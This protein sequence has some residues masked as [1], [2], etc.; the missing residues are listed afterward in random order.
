MLPDVRGGSEV[1]ES[2]HRF[3]RADGSTVWLE[4]SCRAVPAESIVYGSARDITDRKR[5]EEDL[6]RAHEMVENSRDELA[7]SRAR[8]VAAAAEERQRVVR[9]IHDGAQQSLVHTIITLKMALGDAQDRG[10]AT[11]A[12]VGEA[13]GHAEAA[14]AKLRA[15]A[16][17]ILPPV[18]ATG[19]LRAGI[20]ELASRSS[21]P[22]T[23][24]VSTDRLASAIEATAYFVV[25]ESLTN[26]MKHSGAQ[27][28]EVA[29]EITA[30]ALRV[31]IRDD[32]VG[33]AEPSAS[34]GL[35]GLRDRV[36]AFGGTIEIISPA[37]LGTS[38]IVVIPLEEAA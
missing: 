18:L 30:G 10:G 16:H 23:T 13:L 22:V 17:G 5:S 25:S 3:V 24:D 15:L 29:A 34:S 8:V 26:V 37:G 4:V 7:A 36:E 38:V 11:G 20:E 6:R 14:N 1:V 27:R 31:E 2:E 12:L 32:G 33:G 28:A 19:G 9:D 21:L 35:T